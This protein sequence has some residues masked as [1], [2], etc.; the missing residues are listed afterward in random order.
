M[1]I[2]GLF[3]L[4]ITQV[5]QAQ[6]GASK[7]VH[8]PEVTIDEVAK[9]AVEILSKGV[10]PEQTSFLTNYSCHDFEVS[11]VSLEKAKELFE[12]VSKKDY[13]PFKYPED[14]CYARAHEMSLLLIGKGTKTGKVFIQG[15]LCVD[16]PNSPKGFVTW[17]YHVAPVVNVMVNGEVKTYVIDPSL[18]D[19]PVLVEEWYKI[20]TSHSQQ[21]QKSK[22]TYFNEM[23]HY[24]PRDRNT[25]MS[26]FDT[27][28]LKARLEI[29][30]TYLEIQKSRQQQK[31]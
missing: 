23:F 11:V 22:I 25:G 15:D 31:K 2:V 7:S 10:T 18:F 27:Y 21:A 8:P 12:F 1:P 28:D 6:E 24:A 26:A 29:M 9:V 19:R 16:T 17:A 20:Q 3:F 4:L 5:L 30:K 14:G 13:I